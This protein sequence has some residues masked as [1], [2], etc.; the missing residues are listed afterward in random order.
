MM[1][2]SIAI[3]AAKRANHYVGTEVRITRNHIAD[4]DLS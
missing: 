3:I 4:R 2:M 1:S